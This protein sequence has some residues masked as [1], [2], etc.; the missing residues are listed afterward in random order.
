MII[1]VWLNNLWRVIIVERG[2]SKIAYR[3]RKKE[4]KENPLK[5][6][7]IF[8]PNDHTIFDENKDQ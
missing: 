6:M 2:F 7:E 1:V 5:K 4:I 8:F 3:D